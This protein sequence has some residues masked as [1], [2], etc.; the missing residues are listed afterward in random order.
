MGAH[1]FYRTGSQAVGRSVIQEYRR[2]HSI[3][4][5][6]SIVDNIAVQF[7]KKGKRGLLHGLYERQGWKMWGRGGR[8]EGKDE[9]GKLVHSSL[10]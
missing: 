10:C 2:M 3:V 7:T 1:F 8:S 9:R 4:V 6:R 5:L